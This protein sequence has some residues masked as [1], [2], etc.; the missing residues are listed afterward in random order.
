[1]MGAQHGL[2]VVS[3]FVWCMILSPWLGPNPLLIDHLHIRP[4]ALPILPQGYLD[5]PRSYRG[6]SR[7]PIVFGSP[8]SLVTRV[9]A[10]AHPPF[11]PAYR[12]TPFA[13]RSM[14]ASRNTY[15]P[16]GTAKNGTRRALGEL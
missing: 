8:S 3:V 5:M 10:G 16:F 6:T 13:G 4:T 12:I 11:G 9:G 15:S 1:M 7:S 14:I 2:L